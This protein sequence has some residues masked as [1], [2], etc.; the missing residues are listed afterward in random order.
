V[1]NAQQ[2]NLSSEESLKSSNISF[3][4]SSEWPEELG[5]CGWDFYKEYYAEGITIIDE[6]LEY[7]LSV[8]KLDFSHRNIAAKVAGVTIDYTTDEKTFV[9]QLGWLITGTDL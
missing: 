4:S 9:Q 2:L 6:G 3:A 8:W 1:V 5:E 7:G